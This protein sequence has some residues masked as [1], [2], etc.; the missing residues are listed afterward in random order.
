VEGNSMQIP[1]ERS[2]SEPSKYLI[3]SCNNI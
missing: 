3:D 2:K 1:S